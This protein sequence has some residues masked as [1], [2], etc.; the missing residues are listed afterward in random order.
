MSMKDCVALISK[1]FPI[2]ALTRALRASPVG[3]GSIINV[4]SV[5]YGDVIYNKATKDNRKAERTGLVS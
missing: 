5:I 2:R 3:P 4:T 1:G